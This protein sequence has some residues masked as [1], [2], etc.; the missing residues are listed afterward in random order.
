MV[1]SLR[2]VAG[3]RHLGEITVAPDPFI[4]KIVA[5][6]PTATNSKRATSLGLAAD[7]SLDPIVQGYIEDFLS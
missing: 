5:G 1:E 6:W 7:A 4:Q 3:N 2:R